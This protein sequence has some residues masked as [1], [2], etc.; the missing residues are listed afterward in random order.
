[1]VSYGDEPLDVVGDFILSEGSRGRNVLVC[2]WH[3]QDPSIP[4]REVQL[5]LEDG[6]DLREHLES[7]TRLLQKFQEAKPLPSPAR[8]LRAVQLGS[9]FTRVLREGDALTSL[10]YFLLTVPLMGGWQS[11][12]SLEDFIAPLRERVVKHLTGEEALSWLPL[13]QAAPL[14]GPL[15]GKSSFFT[16]DDYLRFTSPESVA[17]QEATF[18]QVFSQ[19]KAGAYFQDYRLREAAPW[20]LP[21]YQ[22]WVASLTPQELIHHRL[23]FHIETDRWGLQGTRVAAACPPG[24]EA[25]LLEA[26]EAHLQ[27]GKISG[28]DLSPVFRDVD[29]NLALPALTPLLKLIQDDEERD[30][31]SA[32]VMFSYLFPSR[33]H[34]RSSLEVLLAYLGPQDTWSLLKTFQGKYVLDPPSPAFWQEVLATLQATGSVPLLWLE[35]LYG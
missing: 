32:W 30:G 9:D 19:E 3:P 25:W 4:F 11:Y 5:I 27:G 24:E 34:L 15:Q 16:I 10:T 26:L 17:A 7:F 23:L 13:L 2:S 22:T 29:H 18:L 20:H 14:A 12:T 8:L 6:E 31:A 28:R 33:L 1:M 35:S 21:A